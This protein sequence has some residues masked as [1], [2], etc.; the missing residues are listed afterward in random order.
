MITGAARRFKGSRTKN[1]DR[2][3]DLMNEVFICR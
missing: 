2:F 1:Y 3:I